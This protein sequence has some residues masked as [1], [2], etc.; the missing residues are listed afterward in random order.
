MT[1]VQTNGASFSFV[2]FDQ[3]TFAGVAIGGLG[4]YEACLFWGRFRTAF[5]DES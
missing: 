1:M 2:P 3:A 5:R 4:P